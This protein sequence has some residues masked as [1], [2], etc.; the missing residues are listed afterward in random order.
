MNEYKRL[1]YFILG[2]LAFYLIAG[3]STELMGHHYDK[4]I[5]PFFSWLLFTN[6]PLEH[7]STL[8]TL[9]ILS[10]ESKIF[11]PPLLYGEAYGVV[12]NPDSAKS[13]LTIME[14]ADS[15]KNHHTTEINM[16][17][18]GLE[19]NFLPR[20]THYQVI[21]LQY[22]PVEFYKSGKVHD[23]IVLGDFVVNK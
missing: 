6:V 7:Y 13:R 4:N 3:Y 17:R 11:N 10:T 15:L 22:D 23:A 18:T 20:H 12:P 21:E 9:R 16:L 14:L 5:P 19:E 8:R 1:K 2:F